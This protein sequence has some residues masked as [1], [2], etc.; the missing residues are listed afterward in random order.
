MEAF[1]FASEDQVVSQSQDFGD[2]LPLRPRMVVQDVGHARGK[3]PFS[4]VRADLIGQNSR[5]RE[6]AALLILAQSA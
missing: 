5:E 6:A 2:Y 4:V 1:Y 3:S